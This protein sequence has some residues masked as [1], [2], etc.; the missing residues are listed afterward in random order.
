MVDSYQGAAGFERRNRQ[1]RHD[2]VESYR[3]SSAPP[4]GAQ[5]TSRRRRS[6]AA[7]NTARGSRQSPRYRSGGF[8]GLGRR[9]A[10]AL[11]YRHSAGWPC[12]PTCVETSRSSS[13]AV[14]ETPQ[15]IAGHSPG[16]GHPRTK[17][18]GAGD[19]SKCRCGA[20]GG[21]AHG[22]QLPPLSPP[23]RVGADRIF[24]RCPQSGPV[25]RT[26]NGSII[27]HQRYAGLS[28]G[29]E[30]PGAGVR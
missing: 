21:I 8:R 26:G 27:T 13:E 18:A 15:T 6:A 19:V 2:P 28:Q 22:R 3:Y 16:A 9:I 1:S 20:W 30:F 4:R 12:P 14:R 7:V 17:P 23:Q 10:A 25:A 5:R 29:G 11:G 24:A